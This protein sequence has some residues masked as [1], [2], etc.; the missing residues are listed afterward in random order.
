MTAQPPPTPPTPPT[1]P[2][3]PKKGWRQQALDWLMGEYI[4]DPNQRATRQAVLGILLALGA[5]AIIA[6]IALR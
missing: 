2:A 3:A 5:V 4:T 1:A 6:L